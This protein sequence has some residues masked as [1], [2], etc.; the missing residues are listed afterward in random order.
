M[1][2]EEVT[3][4]RELPELH[5]ITTLDALKVFS[6]P[7]RQRIIECLLEG[8]KTVK[9][10][11]AE[12][13]IAPTK[14]YYHIN[15]LEEH[16]LI[17]VTD[18]RIVSGIIEKQY[19]AAASHYRIK[20]A[21]LAPGQEDSDEGLDMLIDAVVEPM[22]EDIRKSIA[23]GLIGTGDDT[24]NSRALR[25]WRNANRLPVEQAEKFYARLDEL[26]EE[27]VCDTDEEEAAEDATDYA[28]L[29]FLYPTT[30]YKNSRK[31]RK[32]S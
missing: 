31:R 25:I 4:T 12:L 5:L 11:A 24:P 26:M 7:L 9:Q 19:D 16:G 13:E 17:R 22:R 3:L 1:Q 28:L 29:L 32:K 23:T 2:P 30:S 18:T 8:S 20:K 10:I 21:L 27:F 14:L 6:D 15:L